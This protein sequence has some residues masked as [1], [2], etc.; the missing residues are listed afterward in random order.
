MYLFVEDKE[1]CYAYSSQE[2]L[3]DNTAI[4]HLVS[5]QTKSHLI[6]DDAEMLQCKNS[7]EFIA[8]FRTKMLAQNTA[9]MTGESTNN[10]GNHVKVN[11]GTRLNK[12]RSFGSGQD[13]SDEGLNRIS[14][15]ASPQLS[16]NS[17]MIEDKL[18]KCV[19]IF[20]N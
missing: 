19:S 15:N 18:V 17:Q 20:G 11:N 9:N 7:A 5:E 1:K 6:L 13:L 16:P 12:Q 4:Q 3:L 8:M 14:N 2:Q 10:A